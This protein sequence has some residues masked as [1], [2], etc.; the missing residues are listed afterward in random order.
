MTTDLLTRVD[1]V[2]DRTRKNTLELQELAAEFTDIADRMR[3]TVD[4]LSVTRPMMAHAGNMEIPNGIK[5]KPRL[6]DVS[7]AVAQELAEGSK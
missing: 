7:S 6:R 2:I 1:D 3:S 5:P 4:R